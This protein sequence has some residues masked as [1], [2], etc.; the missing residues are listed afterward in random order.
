MEMILFMTRNPTVVGCLN[1][2]FPMTFVPSHPNVGEALVM[3]LKQSMSQSHI[4]LVQTVV[5]KAIHYAL[6]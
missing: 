6:M 1:V 4:A 3:S 2:M 5:N